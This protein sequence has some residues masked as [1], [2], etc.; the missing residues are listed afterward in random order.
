MIYLGEVVFLLSNAK[1]TDRGGW[2]SAR[3]LCQA[4]QLVRFWRISTIFGRNLQFKAQKISFFTPNFFFFL[5]DE[6]DPLNRF[7]RSKMQKYV[8]FCLII[9]HVGEKTL[10]KGCFL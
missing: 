1:D 6:N 7:I 10:K 2:S 4:C 5:I 9:V 3:F 8:T